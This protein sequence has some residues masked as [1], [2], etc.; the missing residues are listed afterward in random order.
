MLALAV[1]TLRRHYADKGSDVYFK[2]FE[3]YDLQAG[4]A[5]PDSESKTSYAAL[6]QEFGLTTADVTN[7]L[8]A[9]RRKFR[10]LVLARL[11]DITATEE[12][13]RSEARSLLGVKT[14]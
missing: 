11:R 12:E 13:Y 2:L 4:D 10:E 8:A 1:E 7:Y 14:K 5:D 9:A 6:A 3:L